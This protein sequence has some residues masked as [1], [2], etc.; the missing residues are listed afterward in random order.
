MIFSCQPTGAK[1]DGD[2]G[3]ESELSCFLKLSST[4]NSPGPFLVSSRISYFSKITSSSHLPWQ[5]Q[6]HFLDGSLSLVP[7]LFDFFFFFDCLF[8]LPGYRDPYP[9]TKKFA[10]SSLFKR[11]VLKLAQITPYKKVEPLNTKWIII[12]RCRSCILSSSCIFQLKK[13][14]SVVEFLSDFLLQVDKV[15]LGWW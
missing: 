10:K 5:Q 7:F 11:W 13:K 1:G 3:E 14:T 8:G 2:K 12:L 15:S 4:F 6:V 9:H